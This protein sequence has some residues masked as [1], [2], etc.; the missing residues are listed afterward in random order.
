V[1]ETGRPPSEFGEDE[2]YAN[3]TEGAEGVTG[4]RIPGGD[5]DYD[6]DAY[7]LESYEEYNPDRSGS[8]FYEGESQVKK[9]SAPAHYFPYD[10]GDGIYS[11]DGRSDTVGG[12]SGGGRYCIAVVSSHQQS[13]QYLV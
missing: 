5:Q 1:Y 10:D 2:E 8:W 6:P 4:S 13:Q 11:D 9:E 3:D 12:G 7:A